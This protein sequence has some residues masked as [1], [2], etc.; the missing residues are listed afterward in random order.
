MIVIVIIL[1]CVLNSST[2]SNSILLIL[3]SIVYIKNIKN[4]N[5]HA[6]IKLPILASLI[7]SFASSLF[8]E[9]RIENYIRWYVISLGILTYPIKYDKQ[10]WHHVALTLCVAYLMVFQMGAIIPGSLIYELRENYYPIENNAWDYQVQNI[11]SQFGL[12]FQNGTRAA[13]IF[14]NPNIMGQYIILIYAIIY[15]INLSNLRKTSKYLDFTCLFSVLITGSRTAFIVM[16]MILIFKHAIRYKINAL[17]LFAIATTTF[18]V[19]LFAITL[20]SSFFELNLRSLENLGTLFTDS[21]ESG[22]VKYA[23]LYNYL[24]EVRYHDLEE[25]LIFAFGKLSWDRQFDAEIGY[26][27]QFVGLIGL[28]ALGIFL[29]NIYMSTIKEGKVLFLVFLIAVGG[30]L[31]MNY[32]FSILIFFMLSLMPSV[33]K[34]YTNKS[35]LINASNDRLQ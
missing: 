13:G 22:T 11:D 4:I 8:F 31:F 20:G 30:T 18:M 32:R 24:L 27:I 15:A 34:V 35:A 10:E 2:T 21:D 7:I 6:Y 12:L 1:L 17:I 5:K 33:E 9:G 28:T 19:F 14:Y 16:M 3:A 23:I 25:L 26:M 29:H